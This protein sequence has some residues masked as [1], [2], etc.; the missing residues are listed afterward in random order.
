VS[1]VLIVSGIVAVGVAIIAMS[2]YYEERKMIKST[3]GIRK[4]KVK[5]THLHVLLKQFIVVHKSYNRTYPIIPVLRVK[6]VVKSV[7]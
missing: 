5:H 4:E 3:N 6:H 2:A 7:I 1:A